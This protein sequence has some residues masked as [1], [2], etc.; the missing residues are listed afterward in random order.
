MV[1][2]EIENTSITL[3]KREIEKG[4][5]VDI[6]ALKSEIIKLEGLYQNFL[7]ELE[8][9]NNEVDSKRINKKGIEQ[10]LNIQNLTRAKI[11]EEG[12]WWSSYVYGI[13]TDK[14]IV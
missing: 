11:A 8:Y 7:D 2:K 10:A 13:L 1:L 14:R 5:C 3:L 12:I 4:D 6:S 9:S